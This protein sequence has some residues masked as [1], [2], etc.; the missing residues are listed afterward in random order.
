MNLKLGLA[1]LCASVAAHSAA[2]YAAPAQGASTDK[3]QPPQSQKPAT[4]PG[5]VDN[6]HNPHSTPPA[7]TPTNTSTTAPSSGSTTRRRTTTRTRKPVSS[8]SG[9]GTARSSPAVSGS[10]GSAGTS[11][12]APSGGSTQRSRKHA[13]KRHHKPAPVVPLHKP[14]PAAEQERSVITRTVHQIDRALPAWL[15][16]VLAIAALAL[17]AL[18]GHSVLAA[19][20]GRKLR[21]QRSQL[22]EEVGILQATLLPEVPHELAGLALSVAYSP[23]EGPAAGGDFYDAFPLTDGRAAVIVGDISGHGKRALEHTSLLRYTL[24]AYLG[25]GFEPRQALAVAERVLD[26]DLHGDFATV[27]VAVFDPDEGVFTYASAGH[28]PPIVLGTGTFEPITAC[29]SPPIGAQLPT[30]RR[31]TTVR[32]PGPATVCFFTDGLV[33]GRKE[34]AMLGKERLTELLTTPPTGLSADELLRGV[35]DEIDQASDDMAVCIVGVPAP[36]VADP[37]RLEELEVEAGEVNHPSLRRFIDACELEPTREASAVASLKTVAGEFGAAVLKVRF[38][39]AE[40][41]VTVM[42]PPASAK[43]RPTFPESASFAVEA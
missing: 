6:P 30:G 25:A 12:R 18:L 26:D 7:T 43:D 31:Q 22:L 19:R 4:P 16:P 32:L 28:P 42:A 2:S 40:T 29:A 38:G 24:R 33:E 34:G 3:S 35:V 27:I 21:R 1:L 17:L 10:A 9:T 36:A 15:K 11:A 37:F 14:Q 41:V 5:S 20:R 23:A 8:G 13:K 39:S